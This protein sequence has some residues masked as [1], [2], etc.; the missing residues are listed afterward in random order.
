[1]SIGILFWILMIIWVVFWGATRVG[2]YNTYAP[3][4]NILLLVLLGLLGWG[5]FG[6]PIRG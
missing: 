4:G 5:V 3:Y 2:P 1:M 6:A